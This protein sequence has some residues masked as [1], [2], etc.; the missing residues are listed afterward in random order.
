MR[1]IRKVHIFVSEDFY[2]ILEDNRKKTEQRLRTGSMLNKGLS[3]PMF[4]Q[5]LANNK[6]KLPEI[7]FNFNKNAKIKKRRGY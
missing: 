1:R 5:L 6:I 2:K 3:N 4:T 7:T